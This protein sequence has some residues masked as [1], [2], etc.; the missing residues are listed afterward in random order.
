MSICI[1][2][3][4]LNIKAM[5]LLLLPPTDTQIIY[6]IGFGFVCTVESVRVDARK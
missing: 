3:K 1:H 6:C 5:L 2:R 4:I